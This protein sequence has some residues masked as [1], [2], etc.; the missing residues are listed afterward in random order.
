MEDRCFVTYYVRWTEGWSKG[1][2]PMGSAFEHLPPDAPQTVDYRP[3]PD[4]Y[5]PPY[6]YPNP[7]TG[8]AWPQEK[9]P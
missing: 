6:H 7:V 9:P 3:Y 4:I 8:R 5:I 2:V 1:G